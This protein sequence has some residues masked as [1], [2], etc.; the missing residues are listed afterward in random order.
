MVNVVDKVAL[1]TPARVPLLDPEPWPVSA[2]AGYS[3]ATIVAIGVPRL[4][5]ALDIQCSSTPGEQRRRSF[6]RDSFFEIVSA[7]S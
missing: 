1:E 2:W 7:G 3:G 4:S 6:Q 5:L